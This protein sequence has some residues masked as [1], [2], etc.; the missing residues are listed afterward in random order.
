MSES[1]HLSVVI[2]AFNEEDNLH[3]GALAVVL[4]Y[5]N[6]QKYLWELILV[7][8]GSIDAT[9]TLLRDFSAS[10]PHVRVIDNPHMGKQASV[11]SG[12]L[13]ARGQIILFSDMDQA[14]PITEFDK[15]LPLFAQ[16]Q[17]IVIG[18]RSGRPNAPFFRKVLAL[19]MVICRTL[20]LRLPFKDTQ[21]GFKA[22]T[23]A[24][25]SQIFEIMNRVHPPRPVS[26]PAV[27][28]GFDIE[29]LYLG[30]KLNFK[31]AEVPV[32]WRH[33][34]TRRVSFIKDALAGL[35]GLLLVRY[36]SLTHA[37]HI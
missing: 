9:S 7:N 11:I 23:R 10:H 24:A 20:V 36:R 29:L 2:P 33:Q 6:S 3:R 1:P 19:G 14:T 30:R 12:A 32:T 16:H 5:L 8:D 21:C 28:P 31:I 35:T 25:S 27:D 13:I 37:Y 22:F 4:D 15:F 17:D 26:G 18:T 34:E